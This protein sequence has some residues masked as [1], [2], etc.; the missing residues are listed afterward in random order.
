MNS[1]LSSLFSENWIGLYKEYLVEFAK[2]YSRLYEEERVK[3]FQNTT[4]LIEDHNNNFASSSH[5][6]K[7]PSFY[8]RNNQFSDLTENELSVLFQSSYYTDLQP[9]QYSSRS[10]HMSNEEVLYNIESLFSSQS[11][12]N[13]EYYT[14]FN[15]A[16]SEN[17][18][19]KPI[20]TSV[21][22]QGLCGGCW[23]FVSASCTEAAI[24]KT[25]NHQISLSVQELLDC[26][27]EYDRGCGGGNP[28]NAFRYASQHCT[29]LHKTHLIDIRI[30]FYRYIMAKGLTTSDQ[31]PLLAQ[32]AS[33]G[34]STTGYIKTQVHTHINTYL[35]Y[36]VYLTYS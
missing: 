2:P 30:T 1:T 27:T 12:Q 25:I 9:Q 29:I 13:S 35:S 10:S 21:R 14:T 18:M 20:T 33:N 32:A 5:S 36:L 31:Y 16:T 8:L 19:K 6:N 7:K 3:H 28:V 22:N 15:W 24:A 23:A 26:D 34:G 17:P 11:R 4:I